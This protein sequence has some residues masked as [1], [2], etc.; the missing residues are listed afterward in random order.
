MSS[1]LF[2]WPD[3]CMH[4]PFRGSSSPATF[5]RVYGKFTKTR[6]APVGARRWTEVRRLLLVGLVLLVLAGGRSLRAQDA[7]RSLSASSEIS[8]VTI[9]PGDAVHTEF[10]HSA[11]HVRDPAQ[12]INWL[13]NYGTFD[14]SDPFFLPKFT[15]GHLRYF[16]SVSDYRGMLRFYE[17]VGRPVITQRLDLTRAQRTALFR[18]LQENARPE[19]RYYQYDFLFDNC[20]TRVRDALRQ[21][22]GD[23]VQFADRPDP[24]ASFRQMLDPYVADRPLL[25][26]GFD[27]A[28]GTPTDRDVSAREAMFLPEPLMQAVDHASVRG[29]TTA[30]PLVTATDT[31][32]WFEGYS[33]TERIFDWPTALAWV[34]LL[35]GGLWTAAQVRREQAP[36]TW[37]DATLLGLVGVAGLAVCYLWFISE[38]RVTNQNW[39]LLWAWPTHVV[40]AVAVARASTA[41]WLRY[42][43]GITAVGAVGVVLGW[44]LWPQPLHDA[45]LPLLLA[46]ALRTGWRAWRHGVE[47]PNA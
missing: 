38:H 20:S 28:L 17:R 36:G 13:Y 14:F 22:L 33:S 3:T 41:R 19:N 32:V 35:V 12:G 26:L 29:D 9:L 2:D 34:L 39:N 18:F 4:P 46:L 27:L 16:L 5:C 15:Y 1:A 7:V 6:G 25:D 11:L 24:D 43:E 21:A 44:T 45:V 31:L 23:A 30:R 47:P 37:T 10:G 42:Y 8:L 40:A